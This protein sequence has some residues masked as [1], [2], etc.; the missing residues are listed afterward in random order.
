M[1]ACRG[2]KRKGE[3]Q[4]D[5]IKLVGWTMQLSDKEKSRERKRARETE[6]EDQESE[7]AR[8]QEKEKLKGRELS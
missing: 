1:V 8:E 7:R 2:R 4:R 6:R 5:E 3:R